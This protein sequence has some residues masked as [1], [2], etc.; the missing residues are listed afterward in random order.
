VHFVGLFFLH[1]VSSSKGIVKQNF[2]KQMGIDGL[3]QLFSCTEFF[4]LLNFLWS[5]VKNCMHL[6]DHTVN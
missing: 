6:Y 4:M 1:S 5:S 2:V 3:I